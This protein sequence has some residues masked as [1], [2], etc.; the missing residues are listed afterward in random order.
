[1]AKID[2]VRNVIN[3]A[4][5]Q[6]N[7]LELSQS[8][9]FP[10]ESEHRMLIRKLRHQKHVFK[11]PKIGT[12][13]MPQESG[14]ALADVGKKCSKDQIAGGE[15]TVL[16]DFH[17]EY[18]HAVQDGEC[19]LAELSLNS[20][21]LRRQA[22]EFRVGNLKAIAASRLK[23]YALRPAAAKIVFSWKPD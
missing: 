13:N 17:I 3:V 6:P 20:C 1:M 16:C 2:E 23:A 21:Y 18:V 12:I 14:V 5:Q 7:A 9:I 11:K 8:R 15:V 22:V 10:T 19:F 4:Y